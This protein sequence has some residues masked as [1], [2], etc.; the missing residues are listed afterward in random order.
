MKPQV[1]VRTPRAPVPGTP[2]GDKSYGRGAPAPEYRET[3]EA[4]EAE[5]G[6]TRVHALSSQHTRGEGIRKHACL[7][8]EG[9]G[10]E[11]TSEAKAEKTRTKEAM[12]SGT[13]K[14]M[15]KEGVKEKRAKNTRKKVNEEAMLEWSTKEE[16]LKNEALGFYRQLI[17]RGLKPFDGASIDFHR[18][19]DSSSPHPKREPDTYCCKERGATGLFNGKRSPQSPC[20][21]A[22]SEP[23][24]DFN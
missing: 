7:S 2:R 9:K 15:T 13:A 5:A 17:E 18:K 23:S 6:E 3:A 24:A 14:K 16:A 20:R 12:K 21:C 22:V 10:G 4:A 19:R 8:E 1:Q 11:M